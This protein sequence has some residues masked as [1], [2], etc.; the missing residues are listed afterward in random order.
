MNL[1]NDTMNVLQK[2]I[3]HSLHHDLIHCLE[4]CLKTKNI[5]ERKTVGWSGSSVIYFD[6][7]KFNASQPQAYL[8][9][10]SRYTFSPSQ[11]FQCQV[12]LL[13][14]QLQFCFPGTWQIALLDFLLAGWCHVTSSDQRVIKNNFYLFESDHLDVHQ[15]LTEL[16]ISLLE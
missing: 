2:S 10:H 11:L 15:D 5:Y 3:T 7:S 14:K 9:S 13:S 16:S 8:V 12:E 4:G 1:I 6:S